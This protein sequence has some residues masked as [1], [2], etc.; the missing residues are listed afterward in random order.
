MQNDSGQQ[1]DMTPETPP[2][3]A[4]AAPVL[5]ETLQADNGSLIGVA[6]LNAEKTL[7]AL[8]LKMVGLLYPQLLAWSNDE[9][10]ALIVLQ[11]AGDKA[12]CAG[13]DLQNL[14]KSMLTHHASPL[15]D[16]IRENHYAWQFF[17]REYRLDYLIHTCHKPILAWGHG[18]TMGGGIGLLAGASHRVVTEKSRLAMPEIT[19]GLFPDVG[20]SWFMH[21]MPGK[22]GLFMALT[23]VSINGADAKFAGLADH[24]VA[25]QDKPA[26]MEA[27]LRQPWA[28]SDARRNNTLLGNVLRIFEHRNESPLLHMAGPLQKHIDRIDMLCAGNDLAKIVENILAVDTR[29]PWLAKASA[30][31]A[32]GSPSSAALA[33]ALQRR[34]PGRTLAD[35][36]RIEFVAAMHCAARPDFAE[37]VRALLI[38]KDHQPKWSPATLAEVTPEW[39]EGFFASPWTE[40]THPLADLKERGR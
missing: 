39:V 38:D 34:M 16:D 25:Q 4:A 37:G 5:F 10:I 30:T 27:L 23:G 3:S 40:S 35:V 21:R 19:I 13:G 29:D 22:L 15:R 36:F 24:L 17:E 11:A 18:I 1:Q 20:G 26:L 6:T 31:L 32:A 2:Q 14:Y 8:S 28:A 33:H 7:N 12:F 9:K